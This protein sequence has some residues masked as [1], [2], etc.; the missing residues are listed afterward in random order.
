M[1]PL[2]NTP[3]CI[4]F[5]FMQNMMVCLMCFFF[6]VTGAVIRF[7]PM[8]FRFIVWVICI[9]LFVLTPGCMCHAIG[10]TRGRA[11]QWQGERR[12]GQ[13]NWEGTSRREKKNVECE[14]ATTCMCKTISI[15]RQKSRRKQREANWEEHKETQYQWMRNTKSDGFFSS[16]CLLLFCFCLF[17]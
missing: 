13:E 14:G 4:K 9:S 11:W 6:S 17:L 15:T 5:W 16:S 12:D 3:V 7:V 8:S 1:T 10:M 2:E